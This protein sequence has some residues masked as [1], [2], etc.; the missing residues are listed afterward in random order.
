MAVSPETE[1]SYDAAADFFAK[2]HGY[3]LQ[4]NNAELD[5]E[6]DAELHGE[7]DAKLDGEPGAVSKRTRY[8]CIP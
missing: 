6:L 8:R 1:D 5:A 3:D 4:H 7:L 2:L